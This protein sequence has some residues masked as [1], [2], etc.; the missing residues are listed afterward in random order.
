MHIAIIMDG[1]GRWAVNRNLNRHAGHRAGAKAA[2][3]IVRQAAERGV[4]TLTLLCLLRRQLVSAASGSRRFI[5]A[6][7]S[8]S[9]HRD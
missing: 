7:A 8:L 5:R 6:S 9:H 2:D 3:A 4:Q 1:N